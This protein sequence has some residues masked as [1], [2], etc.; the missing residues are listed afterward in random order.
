MNQNGERAQED[1]EAGASAMTCPKCGAEVPE[2]LKFCGNCGTQL[3]RTCRKCGTPLAPGLKFCG[4]CGTPWEETA[5]KHEQPKGPTC[6]KCGAEIPDGRKFCVKC[7][8]Q[9]VQFCPSCGAQQTLGMPFCGTCGAPMT[10]AAAAGGT[11]LHPVGF[12][13]AWK[14]GWKF[15]AKGRASRGEYWWRMLSILIEILALAAFLFGIVAGIMFGWS[16][17]HIPDEFFIVLSVV[18]VLWLLPVSVAL[19]LLRIRRLHDQGLSGWW[20]LLWNTP[21]APPIIGLIFALR[22]GTRGPNQ[23]GPVPGIRTEELQAAAEKRQKL[24]E[25]WRKA[26]EP[27]LQSEFGPVPGNRPEELQVAEA[28]NAALKQAA[29]EKRQKR[30][31][32][33]AELWRKAGEAELQFEPKIRKMFLILAGCLAVIGFLPYRRIFWRLDFFRTV[34]PFVGFFLLALPG[35]STGRAKTGMVL[36][37]LSALLMFVVALIP[38]SDMSWTFVWLGCFVAFLWTHLYKRQGAK[39]IC[40]WV[41]VG[42]CLL[43]CFTVGDEWVWGGWTRLFMLVEGA[44]WGVIA[45]KEGRSGLVPDSQAPEDGL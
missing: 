8:A 25:L 4:E 3:V 28:K 9:V 22:S 41:L 23:F 42:W 38:P 39:K 20:V 13:A 1:N 10:G 17:H 24:A 5:E 43:W 11:G 12:L 18:Y 6:P 19:L 16:F 34:V 14:R 37:A 27:V 30:K 31:A 7:G 32:A 36:E 35:K 33:V 15:S 21:P 45:L 29:A 26:S 2:G 44:L 40:A